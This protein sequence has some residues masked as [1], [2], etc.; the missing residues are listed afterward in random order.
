MSTST[1]FSRAALQPIEGQAAVEDVATCSGLRKVFGDRVAVDDVGFTI[2]PGET[3]G[4]LGPNGAGK[5]TTISMLCGLVPL[6]AGSVTIAGQTL[7]RHN[8]AA[9]AAIGLVP[10]EIA[11]YPDLSARENLD[12]FGRLQG[13]D[14]HQRRTRIDDVLDVVGLT[15]RAG[16]RVGEYSGGM[17]RRCNIAVGLLHQ[18]ELLVLDEPTVGVDPQSRN[19]ILD[20]IEALGGAGLSVLYTTHYMEEAERLCD[21]IGIMDTGRMIAEGTRRQLITQVGEHDRIRI[22]TTDVDLDA[23]RHW[24]RTTGPFID[25]LDIP[26]GVEGQVDN[27]RRAVAAVVDGLD[28]A[29][30]E[31]S[32]IEVIEPDLETVFLDLTGRAFRD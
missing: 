2:A 6:D 12:Y 29:A 17:Q 5:T 15:D 21:R 32:G 22:T 9:K 11:L 30:V 24:A 19:Q 26:G 18:P 20:S 13:L 4:L 25:V 1:R 16:D 14:R 23:L 8:H 27:G 28:R 3:Y 31:V 7:G 10:Q